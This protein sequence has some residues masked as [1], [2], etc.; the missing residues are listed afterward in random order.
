MVKKRQITKYPD[1]DHFLQ[2][3]LWFVDKT[4]DDTVTLMLSCGMFAGTSGVLEKQPII[5]TLDDRLLT[6]DTP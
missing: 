1:E 3:H 5:N 2:N 4:H 6:E